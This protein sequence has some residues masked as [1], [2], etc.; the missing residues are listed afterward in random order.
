M[1]HY[2]DDV[3][4]KSAHQ[5]CFPS[6]QYISG[7]EDTTDTNVVNNNPKCV[8]NNTVSLTITLMLKTTLHISQTIDTV[9]LRKEWGGY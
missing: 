8:Y 5:A 6:A 9:Y 7:W 1:L 3:R 4:V 2:G